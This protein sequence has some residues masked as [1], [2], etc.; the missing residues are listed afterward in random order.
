MSRLLDRLKSAERKRSDLRE[1][2]AASAGS[3][4]KSKPAVLTGA[5]KG[6]KAAAKASSAEDERYWAAVKKRLAEV[7]Q[8]RLVED[9]FSPDEVRALAQAAGAEALLAQYEAESKKSET[10]ERDAA[11]AAA[12]KGRLEQEAQDQARRREAAERKLREAAEQ[13][14]RSEAGALSAAQQ[15]A[16]ADAQASAQAKARIQA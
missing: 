7:E 15:R 16:Q 4:G 3:P 6:N 5:A 2:R 13:R 11:K 9:S 12:E 10:I 1:R 14:A 8:Q